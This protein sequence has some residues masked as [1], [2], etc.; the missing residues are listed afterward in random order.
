MKLVYKIYRI[1]RQNSMSLSEKNEWNSHV[2]LFHFTVVTRIPIAVAHS[3]SSCSLTSER[4]VGPYAQ[5]TTK[6]CCKYKVIKRY[7]TLCIDENQLK[8]HQKKKVCFLQVSGIKV[9]VKGLEDLLG[10]SKLSPWETSVSYI[11]TSQQTIPYRG[12][13]PPLPLSSRCLQ[14]PFF[15]TIF[16]K[17]TAIQDE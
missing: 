8:T 7:A 4:F 6:R 1:C 17:L 12:F 15:I 16:Q 14:D 3:R 10:K 11:P 5:S 2:C 13:P 9:S